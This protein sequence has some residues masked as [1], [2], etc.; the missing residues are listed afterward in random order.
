MTGVF[1]SIA[2]LA[3]LAALAACGSDDAPPTDRAEAAL[4]E[5]DDAASPPVAAPPPE[6]ADPAVQEARQELT[7]L[8]ETIAADFGGT[9]G[10]AVVDLEDGWSTG[11]NADA[12]LPQQ[13]VSKLWVALTALDRVDRGTL[14]LG[15]RITIARQDLTVFHQPI[16]EEVLRAGSLEINPLDLMT[17]AITRS[18]NTANDALLWAVGGP[19]AVRAML[20]DKGI[21]KVRFGP[22]ERLLQ[23]SIAGLEWRQEWAYTR[24]GFY[25]ARDALP[26]ATRKRAFES[27]L[28]D[29]VDGASPRAIATALARLARGELLAPPTTKLML[30]TLRETRSGPRRLKGGLE[31]GW[32]IAHK[33][34][35]GQ[36]YDGRQSGYNDVALLFAPDGRTYAVAVMIGE[37]RQGVPGSTAMMQ[38]VTRAVEDYDALL[39]AD[40]SLRTSG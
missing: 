39:R 24:Q 5:R 22:G 27:Y 21:A 6:T 25:D 31:Q 32:S 28:A 8:L 34:G 20:R 30:D 18:D 1:R 19:D 23:S 14:T 38:K 4:A 36:Y 15:D 35:T 12:L 3:G 40:E 33:T 29:P 37:T 10:I 26:D 9:T 2:A 11:V 16:R 7:G 17:R 13:S